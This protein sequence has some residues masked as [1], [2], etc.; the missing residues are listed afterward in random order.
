[1]ETVNKEGCAALFRA[2]FLGL[3]MAL[4][5]TVQAQDNSADREF[6]PSIE[7]EQVNINH[8]DAETIARVLDGVG[9]SRAQAIVSYREE[10][11]DFTD[12]E[13]LLMVKGIGEVTLRNNAVKISF[14]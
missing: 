8:A 9:I 3:L 4:S 7:T 2:V 13:D 11:G 6:A 12:M 10:Y 1:M 14:E 5:W